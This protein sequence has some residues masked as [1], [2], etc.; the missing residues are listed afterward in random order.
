MEGDHN[1]DGHDDSSADSL[2][3]RG[4]INP[5]LSKTTELHC[6]DLFNRRRPCRLS[7][8]VL[9]DSFIHACCRNEPRTNPSGGTPNRGIYE[10]L[11]KREGHRETT[12]YSSTTAFLNRWYTDSHRTRIIEL[13]CCIILDRCWP[14]GHDSWAKPPLL[15]RVGLRAE[16]F[17]T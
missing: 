1:D 13:D 7:S 16:I 3:N 17:L 2:P 11:K 15:L 5:N 14:A 8:L 6:C 9:T 12:R 10:D 4:D